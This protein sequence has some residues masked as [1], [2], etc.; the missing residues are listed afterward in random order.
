MQKDK[1]L[2]HYAVNKL[3][4]N[5]LISCIGL[6]L[7]VSS[8]LL[9]SGCSEDSPITTE[10]EADETG[11]ANVAS[12]ANSEHRTAL[13]SEAGLS[14][15]PVSTRDK[16]ITIDWSLID[17][18]TK[19]VAT[20]DFN[21]PFKLDGDSVKLQA[22]FSNITLEQAQHSLTVG[23]ASNEPLDKLLDQLGDSY[24]S[25]K[26]S[27]AEAKLI[28]YTTPNVKP[29]Q[30]DYVIAHEFARGLTLPIE[31]VPQVPSEGADSEPQPTH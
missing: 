2:N 19:A 8:T 9:L 5:K 29:S 25:H 14:S 13:D 17:S 31:I 10:A 26:F 28:V 16:P 21:Y 7:V 4:I 1:T 3:P 27:E 11:S 22:E 12:T 24:L 15:E 23:M 18:D 6:S 30:H 20:D